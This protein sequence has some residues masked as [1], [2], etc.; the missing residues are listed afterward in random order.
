MCSNNLEQL[1]ESSLK[2]FTSVCYGDIRIKKGAI[3][4]LFN[5]LYLI[6]LIHKYL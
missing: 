4:P 3:K 2:S 6:T 1:T 5:W